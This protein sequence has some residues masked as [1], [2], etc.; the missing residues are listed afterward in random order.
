MRLFEDFVSTTFNSFAVF[1][2]GAI[3]NETLLGGIL[4][5]FFEDFIN[6]VFH[7]IVET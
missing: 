1:K 7:T 4:L 3:M 6:V 2:D 5:R